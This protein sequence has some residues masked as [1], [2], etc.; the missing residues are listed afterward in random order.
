MNSIW[1]ILTFQSAIVSTEKYG[2]RR[3]RS[4]RNGYN[5]REHNLSPPC[6][7]TR[8]A[9]VYHVAFS[10]NSENDIIIF[11]NPITHDRSHKSR[12]PLEFMTE[13]RSPSVRLKR[14]LKYKQ[15]CQEYY[16]SLAQLHSVSK[17][18]LCYWVAEQNDLG[19]CDSLQCRHCNSKSCYT[20]KCTRK[21]AFII[22]WCFVRSFVNDSVLESM[23]RS[24][25][26]I[27]VDQSILSRVLLN[28]TTSNTLNW[29]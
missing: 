8:Q 17:C 15:T 4:I 10:I 25:Q 29:Y 19:P 24:V 9:P 16:E 28:I 22:V 6:I 11:M 3:Y 14:K 18:Y 27:S 1:H 5:A 7:V 12:I 13:F 2:H 20:S 26:F 23:N 21:R